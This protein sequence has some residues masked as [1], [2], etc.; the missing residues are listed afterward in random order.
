MRKLA[1]VVLATGQTS[2]AAFEVTAHRAG[3]PGS[4]SRF[5]DSLEGI[6]SGGVRV[7]R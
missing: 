3:T 6:A 4:R 5:G 2:E 7:D 1:A